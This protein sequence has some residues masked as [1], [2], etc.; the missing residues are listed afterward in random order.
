MTTYKT[1]AESKNFIVLDKFT[2][3]WKVT[4]SF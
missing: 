1:V 3:D 4:E 2:K